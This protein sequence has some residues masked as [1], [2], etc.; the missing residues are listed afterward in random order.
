MRSRLV[1]LGASLLLVLSLPASAGAARGQVSAAAAEHAR[2]LAYWTPERIASAKVKDYVRDGSGRLVPNAKPG[3]GGG[4]G[5]VTGASWTGNGYIESRSGRI[6]FTSGSSD[7]ICS[8][9]VVTDGAASPD[10]SIVLTAGHCVYDGN[11]GWSTNFVYMPNFDDSPSYNCATRLFGCWTA[12]RLAANADFVSGGGFGNDT[13]EVDYGFARVGLGGTGG[14]TSTDLDD[15]RSDDLD[16]AYRLKIGG[17]A[18]SDTQWAFGYPAAG[19]YKGKDL[20][21]CKGTTTADPYGAD[22]WGMNCN[23]TG[24]SSGGPWTF[25]SSNPGTDPDVLV[26]SVNSY[27]YSGIQK[28]FGPKFDAETATVLGDTIDGSATA[29]VTA[30]RP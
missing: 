29:G 30:F 22:T 24:G 7:Y 21:Y 27:G 20:I 4:S 1:V 25:G 23:M 13:V 2:I 17:V 14:S 16:G 15:Y 28:M 6:L 3:G 9:S 5:S 10:F 8:G 11:D 19:K 12:T 18:F 26:S